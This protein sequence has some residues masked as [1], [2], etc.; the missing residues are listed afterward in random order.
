M[1]IL[2]VV[3]RYPWPARR[4]DQLRTVQTLESLR[5]EHRITLLAPEPGP[6]SEAPPSQ[7]AEGVR[8]VLY[9]PRSLPGRMLGVARAFFLGLP[10]Q[11]G[12]YDS[13]DLRRKVRSEE[14]DADLVILQLVRLLGALPGSPPRPPLVVDLIDSLSL[15]VSRR[16]AVDRSWLRPV[17][18]FEARRLE[19]A[20]RRLA[21]RAAKTV[22]VAPRD[23]RW[24]EERWHSDHTAGDRARGPRNRLGVVPL[25]VEPLAT[26][27]A[28][29][30]EEAG[31]RELAGPQG[32]PTVA[33]TGNLGYFVN[34]DAVLWWLHRVWPGLSTA[35]PDLRLVVA[36]ARPPRRL[37]RAVWAAGGELIASPPDLHAI[38]ARATVAVAPMRAGSGVP[39]KVLEAWSLG[40]P[41]VV[42]GW[43]AAGT[44]GN[45]GE[46]F[47]VAEDPFEWVAAI[48]RVLDDPELGPSLAASGRR[49]LARDHSSERVRTAWKATLAAVAEGS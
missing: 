44:G 21:R 9:R 14:A 34:T 24:L 19:S 12:L 41:L 39:V 29:G 11:C 26:R 3:S 31:N 4:G 42:S 48:G 47:L 49:R 15:N 25:A 32:P 5:E 17:L 1:R 33:L 8:Q 10:L 43:A 46:D 7:L 22:L 23:L 18:R 30:Q 36:G 38:L 45:E 6:E 27:E 2:L 13:P 37:Q 28:R 20:E 16:A 35:R 40:V